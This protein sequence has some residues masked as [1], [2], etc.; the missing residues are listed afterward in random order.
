[1]KQNGLEER[2]KLKVQKG[3]IFITSMPYYSCYRFMDIKVRN[4]YYKVGGVGVPGRDCYFFFAIPRY[5][6]DFISESVSGYKI[7]KIILNFF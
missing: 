1:M 3:D 2:G 7:I 4:C 6:T 5:I